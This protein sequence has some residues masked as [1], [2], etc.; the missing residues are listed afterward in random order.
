MT[1]QLF[2][3]I[4]PIAKK[5]NFGTLVDIAHELKN[6]GVTYEGRRGYLEVARDSRYLRNLARKDLEEFKSLVDDYRTCEY[7]DQGIV[8]ELALHNRLRDNIG[9]GYTPLALA[10]GV[11]LGSKAFSLAQRESGVHLI[12]D[13]L[14]WAAGTMASTLFLAVAGIMGVL[15]ILYDKFRID[16]DQSGKM[17][18][19]QRVRRTA[20][21]Q[22]HIKDPKKYP[23]PRFIDDERED[24]NK[25]ALDKL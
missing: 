24:M 11:Y 3:K 7:T 6:L 8:G 19:H 23:R 14:L 12:D 17:T 9:G 18:H 21:V 20:E 25:Y 10:A 13:R 16:V 2:K 1:S 5:S 22:R 4:E 15:F